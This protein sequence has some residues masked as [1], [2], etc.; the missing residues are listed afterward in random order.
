MLL[1]V[2]YKEFLQLKGNRVL[3]IQLPLQS[4]AYGSL[5]PVIHYLILI[6]VLDPGIAAT[7]AERVAMV[8]DALENFIPLLLPMFMSMIAAPLAMPSIAS[9]TENRTLERLLSLPLSWIHV[10]MGKFLFSFAVSLVSSYVMVLTYFG[11]SSGIVE[12]FQPPHL[13]FYLLLLVPTVSFYTVSAALFASVRARSVRSA[14]IF[15]GSLTV[16]LFLLI[17]FLSW[18][19]GVELGKGIIVIFSLVLF[20]VGAKLTYLTTKVN[21]EKLLT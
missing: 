13:Q 7:E 17:F 3:I 2:V 9:E 14:N 18:F 1:S 10:F 15:G 20:V 12:E 11:L 4:I 21:P 19:A 8:K 16:G 5:L 6:E